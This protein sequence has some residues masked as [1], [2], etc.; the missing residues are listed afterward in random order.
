VQQ[1]I[2]QAVFDEQLLLLP[3]FAAR[4]DSQIPASSERE[5]VTESPKVRF[6]FQIL[7]FLRLE[8]LTNYSP[9]IPA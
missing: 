2:T 8:A 9:A 1:L 4:S 5:K 3:R 7:K 6:H